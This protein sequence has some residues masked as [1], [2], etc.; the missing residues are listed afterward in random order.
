M[1]SFYSFLNAA[2]RTGGALPPP[3][4]PEHLSLLLHNHS[5]MS[6][7]CPQMNSSKGLNSKA[8]Q[9]ITSTQPIIIATQPIISFMFTR[10][11]QV[12]QVPLQRYKGVHSQQVGMA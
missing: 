6:M 9:P 4:L 11:N 7:L 10:T 1:S 8:T 2:S 12:G 3:P 5:I